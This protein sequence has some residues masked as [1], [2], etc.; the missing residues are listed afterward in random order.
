M[1]YIYCV[2]LFC[3][4]IRWLG[5]IRVVLFLFCLLSVASYQL[6]ISTQLYSWLFLYC[7]VFVSVLIYI[8]SFFFCFCIRWLCCFLSI[9]LFLILVDNTVQALLL[10]SLITDCSSFLLNIAY[11][12]FVFHA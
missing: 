2:V 7:S 4:C 1:I 8:V 10:S 3:L 5:C 9:V 11:T 6:K 12:C